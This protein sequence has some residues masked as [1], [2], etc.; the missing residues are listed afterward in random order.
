MAWRTLCIQHSRDPSEYH[1]V[2]HDTYRSAVNNTATN[3]GRASFNG[4]GGVNARPTA[5]EASAARERRVQPTS[6]Q[7][8]HQRTA[9]GD[10]G[11]LASVNH[12]RPLT[13]AAARP[14][15]VWA[16][17]NAGPAYN[18]VAG[19]V[20]RPATAPRAAPEQRREVT[21]SR[22]ATAPRA[23]PEQRREVIA[24]R[25]ATAPR[26][27]PEQRREVTASRP[28]TAPR[29]VPAGAAERSDCLASGDRAPS[30][31]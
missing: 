5:Q 22:P 11:Q 10:R 9:N 4:P 29:A 6:E 20:S 25:P 12:G 14:T 2:I 17:S 27:V 26:A 18:R 3:N 30:R 19:N 21:A 23:V 28:A 31:D 7:V 8:A 24:S 13:M 16:R 15:A 1:F